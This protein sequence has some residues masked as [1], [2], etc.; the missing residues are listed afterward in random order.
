MVAKGSYIVVLDTVI[1]DMP[2]D[3][4]PGRPWSKK[5]NPKTAVREF[6]KGTDRFQ[7]DRMID[8]KL[9][10]TVAPEGYLRCIKD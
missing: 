6:I 10:I 8:A 1:E 9:Q 2:E 5:R 7:V 3:F 4:L